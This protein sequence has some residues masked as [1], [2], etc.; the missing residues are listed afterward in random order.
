MLGI[1][2]RHLYLGWF[3]GLVVL[4]VIFQC[5][6]CVIVEQFINCNYSKS[7]E[8]KLRPPILVTKSPAKRV[9]IILF[10][11][12]KHFDL[13]W[14][15]YYNKVIRFNHRPMDIFMHVYT[16][17][18]TVYTPRNGEYNAPATQLDGI[19]KTF[20]RTATYVTFFQIISGG[21]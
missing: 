11:V 10:G 18:K 19:L 2:T 12:P 1:H 17:I 21:V 7:A 3:F 15:A 13:V 20:Y 14:H 8:I 6:Q 9:A 5:V 4:C 16:D